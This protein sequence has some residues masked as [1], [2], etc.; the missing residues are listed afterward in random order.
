MNKKK[1]YSLLFIAVAFVLHGN[2][3][4]HRREQEIIDQKL[5]EKQ[6]EQERLDQQRLERQLEQK[7]VEQRRL[8]RQREDA[9]RQNRRLTATAQA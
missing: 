9:R 2:E 8:E 5:I 7:R 6:L 3:E 1:F 4:Q